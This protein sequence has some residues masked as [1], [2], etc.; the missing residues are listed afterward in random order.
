MGEPRDMDRMRSIGLSQVGA[1]ELGP[2]SRARVNL[3]RDPKIGGQPH[4]WTECVIGDSKS[5]RR[6]F[7]D[8]NKAEIPHGT[9]DK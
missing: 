6:D 8:P 3:D 4:Q 7:S 2:Y 9:A 1:I 5:S